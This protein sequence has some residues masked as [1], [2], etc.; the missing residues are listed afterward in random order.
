[1][2][3]VDIGQRPEPRALCA[4][5]SA[6]VHR[7]RTRRAFLTTAFVYHE[8]PG[9]AR[10][11]LQTA[12]CAQPAH[13]CYTCAQCTSAA[14]LQRA[15]SAQALHGDVDSTHAEELAVVGAERDGERRH[16]D[17]PRAG[18]EV[19]LGPDRRELTVL[20]SPAP[21]LCFEREP[22]GLEEPGR[23]WSG[24]VVLP[25]EINRRAGVVANAVRRAIVSVRAVD[26]LAS[27]I[28]PVDKSKLSEPPRR[29]RCILE[30]AL[31][32][33]KAPS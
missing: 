10:K 9:R 11:R 1:M 21:R 25:G 17:V 13:P 33:S 20:E 32:P 4:R 23:P 19:R 6:A 31:P 22:S 12:P 8:A 24:V 30:A 16:V 26:A 15:V 18:V 7:G 14:C 5:R 29:E 3:R 2:L 27:V 28:I